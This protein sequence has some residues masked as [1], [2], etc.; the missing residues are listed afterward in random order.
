M[1]E[2]AIVTFLDVLGFRELVDSSTA[3]TI[4]RILNSIEQFTKPVIEPTD[5]ISM[6]FEPKVFHFSD[7]IVRVRQVEN[8]LNKSFP[9][10]LLFH[11]ILDLVHAQSELIREGV[12][13]RGGITYGNVSVTE[14]RVFGPGIIGAY[15]LESKYALYPRIV[16]GPELLKEYKSNKLLR[17]DGHTLEEESQYIRDLTRQGGDGI[18]FIDYARAVESELDDLSMY[19]NF[20]NIHR[21][22]IV[23][24]S[25]HYQSLNGIMSKY[26]WLAHY[27]NQTISGI[28]DEW[29]N[30]YGLTREELLISENEVIPLERI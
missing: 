1:Y 28:S 15:D 7:S 23:S 9:I 12:L 10:G 21:E 25:E 20:L 8:N 22:L 2:S 6:D 18:W 4:H 30:Y 27:H 26:I 13:L 17:K 3:E 29:F 11:E 14:S 16:I 19:P 5:G 24:K